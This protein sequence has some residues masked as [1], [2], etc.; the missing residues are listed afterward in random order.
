MDKSTHFDIEAFAML[1]EIMEDEFPELIRVYI[2][3]SDPRLGALKKALNDEDCNELRELSHSL[4]G[5]S[6]NIAALPLADLCFQIEDKSRQNIVEGIDELLLKIEAEY[7]AVRGI[8]I[9][10]IA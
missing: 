2:E 10:I 6:A 3:D 4:K 1:E 8:L 9:S 7:S 5:A